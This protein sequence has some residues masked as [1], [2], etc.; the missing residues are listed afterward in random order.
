MNPK[1]VF[2]L[3]LILAV[4]QVAMPL[5]QILKY[6][7]VLRTGRLYKFHTAPVDPYDAFR[8]RYVAL[9]YVDTD[10]TLHEGDHLNRGDPA[11]V[12]L[13]QDKNGFAQF[14]ELSVDPP[15]AGDYLRVEYI[16][17]QANK[18]H[19]ALPFD[20][21]FME[22]TKAPQ[23]ERAYRRFSNQLGQATGSAYVLVHVK[24]GRGVIEDLYIEDQP[25]RE[26]L[27]NMPKR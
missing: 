22:E 26:F 15:A 12:S 25:V 6:E 20:Q 24:G 23:A 14:V 19:F 4:I 11:Y 27:K 5:G 13:R 10:A 8:G 18:A 2:G 3:F 17:F 1:W 21:Y 7:N 9:N 16:Y